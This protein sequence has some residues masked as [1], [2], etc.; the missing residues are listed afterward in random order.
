MILFRNLK[1]NCK[2]TSGMEEDSCLA[3]RNK[4]SRSRGLF[5]EILRF[6]YWIKPH[7]HLIEKTKNSFKRLWTKYPTK[8]R[9]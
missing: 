2:L 8:G 7:L 9:H 4:E 5:S 3:V 6:F 1:R